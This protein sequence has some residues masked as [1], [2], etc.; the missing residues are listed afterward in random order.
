MKKYIL[1]LLVIFLQTQTGQSNVLWEDVQRR[2][3]SSTSF[4]GHFKGFP[5]LRYHY[6][7][8]Q[9]EVQEITVDLSQT[10]FG[11]ARNLQHINIADQVKSAW[12]SGFTGAGVNVAIVDFTRSRRRIPISLSGV[13]PSSQ[14]FRLRES[15][16]SLWFGDNGFLRYTSAPRI[17]PLE[18]S[19]DGTF[20]TSASHWILAHLIVGGKHKDKDGTLMYGIAKDADISIINAGRGLAHRLNEKAFDFVNTSYSSTIPTTGMT[21]LY[22]TLSRGTAYQTGQLPVYITSGGNTMSS[23]GTPTYAGIESGRMYIGD[24]NAI[25]MAMSSDTFDGRPLSDYLLVV[26]GLSVSQDRRSYHSLHN[27]PGE[28]VE[29]QNRWIMAPYVYDTIQGTSFS[30]PYVTGIASIVKS[31]FPSLSPADVANT[32]LETAI[33]LGAPGTDA[34]YGRGLV[35][36]AN[37]LS[38]Q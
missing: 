18:N 34:I 9:S 38:P 36:L 24:Y 32:L 12:Q 33:D 4:S 26:G 23:I 7:S 25:H 27:R 31:K 22:Q 21:S 6:I 19:N 10:L 15:S 5:S 30:A 13:N 2:E 17:T 14:N 16:F 35:D 20:T 3:V 28:V 37:A 11:K 8:R 29:L 1:A